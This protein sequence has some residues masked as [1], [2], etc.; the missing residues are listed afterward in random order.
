MKQPYILTVIFLPIASIAFGQNF[1]TIGTQ[2]HYSE[3]AGGFAPPNSEYLHLVSVADTVIDGQTTHKIIQT[4]YKY[5]GDTV[6]F[7]PI[8]VFEQSDTV[9]MYSFQKSK[10]LILYIFNGNQGDTLT[11]DIPYTLPWTTDST[12]RLVIDT[13]INT[14][15]DGVQLKKYRTIA[16]DELQFW[17][18]GYFMDRIGGLDWFFPRAIIIPEAGGPIRCYSDTQIDT[19][20]QTIACDYRLISSIPDLT[21]N[22]DVKI[23]PNPTTDVL[24]IKALQAITRI[25]L[26]ELTGKFVGTSQTPSVDLSELTSGQ[27]IITIYFAT[28]QKIEKKIIKN[29]R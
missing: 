9:F 16:L 10:F 23:Y 15:V 2:W 25:D 4:Y 21:D 13:I 17:N 20:F 6:N 14:T 24:T 29:A 1:G 26:Y 28:G 19:S 5:S 11:L 7:D 22:Y 3:H 27:Y 12:Y 8:Y 18:G